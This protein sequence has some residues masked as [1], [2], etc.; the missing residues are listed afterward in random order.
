MKAPKAPDPV[1]TA[2]AQGAMNRDTAVTQQQLNMI[3]QY[4]PYGNLIYSQTGSSFSP[5]ES[6]QSYFWNQQ[7]GEYSTTRPAGEGWQEVKGNLTPKYQATQ[8]LSPEQQGIFNETTQ[9]QT[10]LAKLANEQSSFIRNYLGQGSPQLNTN[11][12]LS[13]NLGLRT[14]LG[15]NT[16]L[17]LKTN[18]GGSYTDRL[19][20]DYRTSV[21]LV[22]SYAGADDFSADRQRYEDAIL[23]RL[24]PRQAQDENAVRNQLIQ[25]GIRPGTN[26]WKA[27][28]E[29]LQSG[30]NDARLGAILSAGDEQARMVGLAR[31]AAAFGNNARLTGAQFGNE[32]ELARFGAQNA[33]ALGK[34]AFANDARGQNA[35]FANDA[36]ARN[37]A[38]YN[39]SI[40]RNAGFSNDARAQNA[41]F[42]NAAILQQ[43]NQPLNELSAVLAGAQIQSPEYVNTPSS[44]VAGVDY[45]GLVNQQYQSKLASYQAGMGGLFGIGSALIGALPFSDRRLKTNIS[46]VGQTKGG[47]PIYS[48][49][50]VWGGP[51]Q[52]GVMADEVPHAAVFDSSSG[53]YRVDY[54]RVK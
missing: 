31:D 12:G 10:N 2:Q 48:Y 25:S 4:T 47:T 41:T 9:A 44:S 5:S 11:L 18:I 8:T 45:T 23:E 35:A 42:N 52:F 43:R 54:S 38:F 36:A 1:A 46:R 15:L 29:R 40:M 6:G 20:G 7:T 30:V 50:Y 51:V 26:A 19:G 32:A 39:D 53:F 37:A 14:N 22:D 28:Y 24:A 33:A 49:Q 21:D 17:G 13:E 16:N 3:D 34:A 27:E